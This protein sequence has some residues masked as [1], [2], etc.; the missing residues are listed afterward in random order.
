MV[1]ADVMVFFAMNHQDG[2]G[3]ETSRFV[4][5]LPIYR[6]IVLS[7]IKISC[8]DSNMQSQYSVSAVCLCVYVLCGGRE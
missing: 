6:R 1:A 3:A 4:R 5:R 2:R 8:H 7:D